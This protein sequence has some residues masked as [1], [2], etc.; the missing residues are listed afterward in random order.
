MTV[1]RGAAW[2]CA[3]VAGSLVVAGC[4]PDE[5][6]PT[7]TTPVETSTTTSAP[8]TSEPTVAAPEMPAEASEATA[9]G[10]EA[11]VEY[12]FAAANYGVSTGDVS[13]LEAAS[14]SECAVCAS[15]I[16][17]IEENY[18]DGGRVDG[19]LFSLTAVASPPVEDSAALTTMQFEQAAGTHIA[20]DGTRTPLPT[21]PAQ[22]AGGVV[23]Y[24]SGGWVMFGIGTL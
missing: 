16:D 22:S 14:G 2:A 1:L 24:E 15:V 20:A 23:R 7:P 12:W 6:E 21:A 3:L 10:A 17:A 8:E 9:A 4:T 19:N 5:P 18:A 11:F 13:P